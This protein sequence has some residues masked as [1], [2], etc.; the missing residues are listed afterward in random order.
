M[1][2]VREI[3][4]LGNPELYEVSKPVERDGLGAIADVVT[5][6][7]DTLMDFRKR[8]GAGRAVASPQIDFSVEYGIL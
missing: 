8:Y 6:I 1:M 3:L 2:A 7:H 5:D 4:L